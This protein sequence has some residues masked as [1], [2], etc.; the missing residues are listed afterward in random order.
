MRRTDVRG[1]WIC[2]RPDHLLAKVN[3]LQWTTVT[4]SPLAMVTYVAAPTLSGPSRAALEVQ[5]AQV[6]AGALARPTLEAYR[7]G[8]RV[9]RPSFVES[10]AC[11]G[12]AAQTMRGR[13]PSK[14]R[15]AGGLV[16]FCMMS[17]ALESLGVFAMVRQLFDKAM[18]TY[19]LGRAG[20]GWAESA[21]SSG[22]AMF[23]A[24]WSFLEVFGAPHRVLLYALGF[25]IVLRAF[26]PQGHQED[27][28]DDAEP[29]VDSPTSPTEPQVPAGVREQNPLLEAQT[30]ELADLKMKHEHLQQDIEELRRHRE[31][32]RLLR[33]AGDERRRG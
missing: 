15:A 23:N 29:S 1:T 12:S 30:A 4:I 19:T 2:V 6:H 18:T 33:R 3:L 14:W 25:C 27:D 22:L 28:V 24:A 16:L 8:P 32:D 13:W 7:A 5:A 10:A 31:V 11:R 20:A 26:A 17:E 21:W 9:E